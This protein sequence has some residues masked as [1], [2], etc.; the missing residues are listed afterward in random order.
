MDW[1]LFYELCREYDIDFE[2][3]CTTVD[4]VE[5][6]YDMLVSDFYTSQ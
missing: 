6:L 1:D 4:D 5:F 2:E 3:R